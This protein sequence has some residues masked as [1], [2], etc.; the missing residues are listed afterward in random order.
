VAFI[1][2][3]MGDMDHAVQLIRGF[4]QLAIQ[5]CLTICTVSAHARLAWIELKTWRT[6]H[7]KN[8]SK[9]TR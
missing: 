1:L 5:F 7:R 2:Y 6:P 4:E 3:R 9:K 8:T